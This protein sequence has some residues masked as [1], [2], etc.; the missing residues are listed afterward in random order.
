M[1]TLLSFTVV[2]CLAVS[3]SSQE[4]R[5]P[6]PR[7]VGSNPGFWSMDVPPTTDT[8]SL[9][10]DQPMRP[11]F[12]A[13]AGPS[14][15]LP[16][17]FGSK[18]RFS[19][20]LKSLGLDVKLSPGTVYVFGINE[21]G[22]AGVGFQNSQ[23]SSV[24]PHF[25]VFQTRGPVAPEKSPPA[26][27][28]STPNNFAMEVDPSAVRA[29]TFSFDRPM[30]RDRHGV[31]L[32]AGGVPVDLASVPFA[33]DDAGQ[34]LTLRYPLRPNT[35]YRATLNSISNIGFRSSEER[36]P[37]WPITLTFRTVEP[38]LP[39]T[40][41]TSPVGGGDIPPTVTRSTPDFWETGVDPSLDR[42][43][44]EFDQPLRAGFS[45]WAGP[46][47]ILP[48]GAAA[49]GGEQVAGKE[50]Y[51]ADFTGVSLPVSLQRGRIYVF[52][53]NARSR[54]G[55]GFQNQKGISMEP[56]Y[57]VFRTQGIPPQ[58][59]RP[60]E[61]RGF[62]P[63]PADRIPLVDGIAKIQ[64]SFDRTMARDSHGLEI[65][66]AKEVPADI[67]DIKFTWNEDA[68]VMECEVPLEAESRYSAQLN[69]DR[70]IGFRTAEG[71]PL[72]P[73]TIRFETSSESVIPETP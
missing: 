17:E 72:W 57:L 50:R 23:G 45:A 41:E 73:I 3:S 5:L 46:G 33:W 35:L 19:A 60:P 18:E 36:I 52:A 66:D 44:L 58:D 25:L 9:T 71:I 32:T 30:D 38:S 11:G 47:S 34:T 42:L 61:F 55:V 51:N 12:S 65:H 39:L 4:P 68:T 13:W 15:L 27:K 37:L 54:P 14:A 6:L 43:S 20:D 62:T 21:R 8:I 53:L 59:L 63:D 7:I 64:M 24:P 29:L 31:I 2:V 49:D 70:N 40:P 1:R 67:A 10:F 48:G 56:R 26:F 22:K 69:S 28:E 16:E